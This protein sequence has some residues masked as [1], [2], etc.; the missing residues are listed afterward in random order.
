MT[1]VKSL[2]L[3][4]CCTFASQ[5][6]AQHSLT[7]DIDKLSNNKGVVSIVVF[8]AHKK[9]ADGTSV[10]IKNNKCS[11]TFKNLK[12]GDYAV[13]YFHDENL[14]KKVD[15]NRI[16]IPTEGIGFS[17]DAMGKFGPKKFKKR[18]VKVNK[19]TR[20]KISTKYM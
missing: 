19:N 4:I 9:Q 3:V 8:D 20:I 6:K 14:N 1:I 11:V 7:V 2:I 16:G 15:K 12:S 18:L 10:K 17:N 13:Q 5:L